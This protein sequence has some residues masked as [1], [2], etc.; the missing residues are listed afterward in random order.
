[1]K[2][3]PVGAE[4]HANRRTDGNDDANSHFSQ[5]CEGAQKSNSYLTENTLRLHYKE[6]LLRGIIAA[7]HENQQ[8]HINT[9]CGKTEFPLVSNHVVQI[10]K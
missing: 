3:R 5:F 10:L 9:E 4:F 1:M 8:Q 6:Q 2:I 7:D